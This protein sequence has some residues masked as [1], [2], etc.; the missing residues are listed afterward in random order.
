MAG[1]QLRAIGWTPAMIRQRRE[2]RK[3]RIVHAGVYAL[4]QAPLS[5][6][7]RWVAAVLT[8]PGTF[9]DGLSAGACFGF[10]LSNENYETV[11]RAGSGGR[12]R[13]GP[14]IVARSTTLEGQTTRHDGLPIVVAARALVDI[15]PSVKRHQLERAFRE[16]IR[17]RTTTA[18]G[19]A[20][21][22][23][24]QRG[25]AV[26]VDLC[27]R[28][29]TIPYH[30]CRSDA[31]SRA[32]EVLHVAG[33][34]PPRVNVRVAGL[35]ADLVWRDRRLIIEIDGARWHLFAE[36]DA[37]RQARWEAAGYTVRRL[38]SD[39]VYSRPHRLLA[40]VSVQ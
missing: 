17:L 4:S 21:I 36:E 20:K 28:Y 30:R 22:L 32:L 1:W 10:H 18:D 23:C 38:P 5:Q 13:H 34:P 26:L 35:E 19:I 31:E 29:A 3:W 6:R 2:H 12:R 15:A 14:L 40:L 9:L 24:G 7:Q 27:D 11:V 37:A 8:E 25:T 33:V 16:S 39:D